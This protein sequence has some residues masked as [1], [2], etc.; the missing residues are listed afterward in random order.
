MPEQLE[1]LTVA[2]SIFGFG[3]DACQSH[4]NDNF[5]YPASSISFLPY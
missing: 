1:M 4:W 5:S 3:T 2:S